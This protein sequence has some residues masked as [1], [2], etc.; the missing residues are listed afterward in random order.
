M[1]GKNEVDFLSVEEFDYVSY[2]EKRLAAAHGEKKIIRTE[3]QIEIATAKLLREKNYH[4]ITVNLIAN[5]A[6]VAHGTFYRYFTDKRSVV[7]KTIADYFRFVRA[8]RLPIPRDASQFEAIHQANL[9]YVECF[10][11]NVGLM[12]CHFRLKDED[13]VIAEVGRHADAAMVDRVIDR[14][15][16]EGEF[17]R[18]DPARLR[19]TIFCLI[20]MV[21]ELLL[22]IY[23]QTQPAL[24]EFEDA[25]QL[26]ATTLS[27]MWFSAI[28]GGHGS[29]DPGDTSSR[30]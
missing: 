3:I 13:E 8:S 28:Y 23:S 20:G 22:K 1:R 29:Q 30:V 6:G 17:D 14:L 5:T 24:A 9:H 25:P 7:A 4:A 12:R 2:L 18:W 27:Q 10:R 11:R 26:V 16:R 21:D 15:R 19:L